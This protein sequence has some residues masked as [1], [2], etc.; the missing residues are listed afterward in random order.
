MDNKYIWLDVL[1]YIVSL[2]IF[3]S[4]ADGA[5]QNSFFFKIKFCVFKVTKT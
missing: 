4:C 3:T 1:V 2:S 5:S